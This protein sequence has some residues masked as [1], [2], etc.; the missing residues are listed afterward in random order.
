VTPPKFLSLTRMAGVYLDPNQAGFAANVTAIFGLASLFRPNSSKLLG[1]LGV[2]LGFAGIVASFSKTGILS[3]LLLL[4]T[5]LVIYT[6]MYSRVDPKIRRGANIFFAILLYGFFQLLIFIAINLDTLPKD[7]RERIQQIENIIT[8]KADKSDTSN[9]A[10]LVELG[11]SKIGERPILGTGY[12]SFTYLL[13]A[14]SQ[15]GDNVGVHN[16]FLR[17]WGEAG[18]IAFMLFIGFWFFVLWKSVQLNLIWQKILLLSLATTTIVY[19]LTVHTFFEDNFIGAIIGIM[20]AFF[21]QK[22]DPSVSSSFQI[23]NT[24]L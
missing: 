16:I 23:S 10:N 8:G 2:V 3:L 1:I 5:T 14:G 6:V 22:R 24:D 21:A 12:L 19:G 4:F 15:T 17:V 18:I 11:L 13:D 20:L 9:R 7:Q